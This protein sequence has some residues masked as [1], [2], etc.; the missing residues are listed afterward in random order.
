MRNVR[1]LGVGLFFLCVVSALHGCGGGGGGGGESEADKVINSLGSVIG[2]IRGVE[3]DTDSIAADV[4]AGR[5]VELPFAKVNN[6][7]I[8]QEVQLTL[9]NL[10]NPELVAAYVKDGVANDFEALTLPPPA[11]YQGVVEPDRGGV[12]V[13]TIN[14]EVVEGNILV[15]PDGWSVI[16]PLE[17]LLL[18]HDFNESQRNAA[19]AKY[20]HVV[21]NVMNAKGHIVVDDDVLSLQAASAGRSAGL[22]G[23]LVLSVVADGDQELYGAYPP[24]GVMPFW[25]KQ[26]ALF[27]VVDWLFNC[28]EPD[29]NDDNSYARCDNAFDGGSDGFQATVR[30]DRLEVWKAGGPAGPARDDLLDQ[31]IVATH[32][33]SPPCCGPPHTAG[34]SAL[35]NFFSGKSVVGGAGLAAGIG[36]LDI[37]DDATCHLRAADSLCH[38]C[39]AQLVAGNEF[40]GTVFLQ[41]LLLAHEI[42]H[43]VGAHEQINPLFACW[44][45]GE[46]CGPNL[47]GSIAFGGNSKYLFTDDDATGRIGPLLEERLG[48]TP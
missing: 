8:T 6:D 1:R 22:G 16:E 48:E 44:L 14:D 39:I 5:T 3:L 17:P 33:A 36:G 28:V 38:H 2:S 11:T 10:R 45:F 42:G 9:R 30:I 46:Q 15:A 47:M 18:Q 12:A 34:R 41:E 13:F 29:A 35:V 24:D 26:E 27:N 25:L 40:P 21:Y 20:N 31:S 4:R 23:S 37:Y 43:V 7:L 19:L 32:E